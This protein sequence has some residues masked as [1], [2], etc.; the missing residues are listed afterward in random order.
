L[1]Q[2]I[3]RCCSILVKYLE[4][5]SLTATRALGI[6]DLAFR[7]ALINKVLSKLWTGQFDIESAFLYSDLN[8]A[9]NMRIPDGY[10]KYILEVHNSVMYPS[11]HALPLNK[12]I[13]GFVQAT[14]NW[15]KKLELVIF[16]KP[17]KRHESL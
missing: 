8:E 2:Q 1:N 16:L 14:K 10:A 5:I 11:T 12:A 9:I 15:W 13:Y 17:R 7:L 6:S 3:K 4:I